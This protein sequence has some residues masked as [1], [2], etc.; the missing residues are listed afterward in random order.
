MTVAIA[1]YIFISTTFDFIEVSKCG[2]CPFLKIL[3]E[4]VSGGCL[5]SN[6]MKEDD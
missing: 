1:A 6:S 2:Y 5:S 4:L 3:N